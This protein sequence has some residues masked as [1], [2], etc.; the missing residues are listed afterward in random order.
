MLFESGTIMRDFL[1][2]HR[3]THE[4]NEWAVIIKALHEEMGELM[5]AIGKHGRG[6]G[7]VSAMADELG[8]LLL[9]QEAFIH[10]LGAEHAVRSRVLGKARAC[11][12]KLKRYGKDAFLHRTPMPADPAVDEG[13]TA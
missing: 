9:V 12:E 7:G 6:L 13:E 5:H 3:A 2:L 4:E 1:A 11:M 8:D 10:Y